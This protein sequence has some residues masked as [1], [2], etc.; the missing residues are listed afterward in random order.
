MNYTLDTN[1]AK[2][3]DNISA[4]IDVS[5]K[6]LGVLTRAEPIT[7]KKGTQGVDMSFRSDTGATADYLTIWTH[8]ADG[9]ALQG[10]NTLMAL[11]T[12][13][14]V[15]ELKA[16]NAE[17]E[18]WDAN[19]GQRTKVV[20]PVFAE[21]M[22]KPVGLVMH[23]EEYEKTTGGTAWKP[24]IAGVFD[25]DEFTASEILSKATKPETLAK[26][27]AALR[28]RP[29]KAG[30]KPAPSGKQFSENPGAGMD[31]IDDLPF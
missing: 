28:N 7:S 17:I 27:V 31:D 22:N 4:R 12:C 15:R 6:Y 29:L 1:A 9:K 5:G 16:V 3:A 24:A 23:M 11:M 18:K 14:R 21:M 2:A 20:T 10:F 13:L 30:S 26:M 25:K 19:V 8:N